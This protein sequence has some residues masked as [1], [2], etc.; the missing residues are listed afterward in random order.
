MLYRFKSQATGDLVMLGPDGKRLLEIWH[1]D[2][3]GEG[4]LLV[5][6]MEKAAAAL[7]ASAD[8][9]EAEVAKARA[10]AAAAGEPEPAPPQVPW[11]ARIQPMLETLQYCRAE[12]A[13][14]RWEV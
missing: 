10:E 1:K 11:R 12:N 7:V 13:A 3:S 8:Q 4:V 2:P 6:D 5:E 14:L 9:E